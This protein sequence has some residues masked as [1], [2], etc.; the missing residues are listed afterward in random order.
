MASRKACGEDGDPAEILKI[1]PEP[2]LENLRLLISAVFAY[3]FTAKVILLYK[4][5]DPSLLGNYRPIALLT[6]TY[7]L[8]Y[9]ILAGKF[10]KT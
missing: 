10:D 6:S 1:S 4:K 7:Q 2:F 5:G 9:L 3:E 8:M